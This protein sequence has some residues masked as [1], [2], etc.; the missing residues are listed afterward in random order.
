[1]SKRFVEM[2]RYDPVKD[3]SARLRLDYD[4]DH[5][6]AILAD[7]NVHPEQ[8]DNPDVNHVETLATMQLTAPMMRWLATHISK[9]ADKMERDVAKANE[10]LDARKD[11]QP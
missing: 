3:P 8:V 2:F 5:G 4:P 7:E 11:K 10:R 6:N 9:L 1:M